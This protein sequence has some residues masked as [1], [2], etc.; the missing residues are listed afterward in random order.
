MFNKLKNAYLTIRFQHCTKNL[1]VFLPVIASHNF[2]YYFLKISFLCFLCMTAITFGT[3]FF[4]DIVDINHDRAH[5]LKKYR[6]IAAG[7][8]KIFE[9]FII[10]TFLILM[11]LGF[12]MLI[13]Y[14]LFFALCAYLI[15]SI[16]YS[17]FLKK[18]IWLD[19]AVLSSLFAIRIIVGNFG[20]EIPLSF[21]LLGFAVPLFFALAL[22]KRLA[23][24]INID[25]I[26]KLIGRGYRS[27]DKLIVNRV[28]MFSSAIC[29]V[30]L[31]LYSFSESATKLY[32][33]NIL[34]SFVSLVIAFWLYRIISITNLGQMKYDPVLFTL[35]DKISYIYGI[36]VISLLYLAKVI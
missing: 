26:S 4:N 7:E 3:Y 15:I 35:T 20:T 16:I 21:W 1:L 5:P 17:L 25:E 12:S 29:I 18:I 34:V 27:R 10:G 13:N 31:L 24:I 36:V 32:S 30:I 2:E 28:V 22:I 14:K 9:S 33:S 8:L 6:P 11:S 23:E 19:A